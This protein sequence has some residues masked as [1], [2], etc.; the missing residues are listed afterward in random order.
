MLDPI[1]KWIRQ[2]FRKLHRKTKRRNRRGFRPMLEA[3]ESRAMPSGFF[4]T[5]GKDGSGTL[6]G[7]IN[8]YYPGSANAAAGATSITVGASSGSATTITAGDLLLVIQVQNATFNTANSP[9]YG[10]GTGVGSGDLSTTAGT[11]EYVEAA[12]SVG[13]GGGT[14]TL[15]GAGS[16]GGLV[17]S[18]FEAASTA[19]HGQET[20]EVVRVPQYLNA[21]LSS[22]LTA[23]AWNGSTGGV[24]ALDVAGT[25]TLGGA[26]VSTNGEGFRGGAGLQSVGR[27]GHLRRLRLHLAHLADLHDRRRRQQGR[28]NCRHPAVRVQ[29]GHQHECRHGTVGDGRLPGRQHG[30]RRARQCRWRR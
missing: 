28:G 27:I 20:F 29:R 13:S 14:L 5:P 10:D 22:S 2:V 4:A 7:I 6:S 17:N 21:T 24:L 16:G 1:E 25:L 9:T 8:T 19:T 11:F 18:Y 26:T 30:P 3:L 15:V 23:A 12:N